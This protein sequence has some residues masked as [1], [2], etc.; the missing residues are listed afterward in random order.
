M[1]SP[2]PATVNVREKF[3]FEAI[4]KGVTY[5]LPFVY[6]CGF[7]VL[8]LFEADYGIA[9]LSLVRVKALAAGLSFA[10][11]IGYPALVSIRAFNC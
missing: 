5:A 7:V 1:S 3:P 2:S 6:V 4:T 9:D 11:F 8:S 10:F